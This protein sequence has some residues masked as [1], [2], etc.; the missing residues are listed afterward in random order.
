MTSKKSSS[1]RGAH[2]KEVAAA[3][4]KAT[5]DQRQTPVSAAAEALL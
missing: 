2:G 4:E 1:A 5:K 3:E